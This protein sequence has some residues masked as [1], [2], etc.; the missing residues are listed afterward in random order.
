L[1]VAA[2]VVGSDT[3]PVQPPGAVLPECAHAR[4]VYAACADAVSEA[5]LAHNNTVIDVSRWTIVNAGQPSAD[6]LI[7]TLKALGH[8]PDRG[9]S[10][11]ELQMAARGF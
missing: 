9:G 5:K 8:C 7:S 1:F 6:R 2:I 3:N 4:T 10:G 11:D